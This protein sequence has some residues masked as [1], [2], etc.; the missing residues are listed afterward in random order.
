[1]RIV[2]NS[3]RQNFEPDL[4]TMLVAQLESQLNLHTYFLSR[5]ES[6]GIRL[7][8]EAKLML[9]LPLHEF[10]I[11]DKYQRMPNIQEQIIGSLDSLLETAESKPSRFDSSATDP[12]V[13]QFSNARSSLTI[14]KAYY[15]K[16]CSIPPFCGDDDR[17]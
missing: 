5:E 7:T 11:R 8:A 12:Y 9:M 15:R 16:Y 13:M 10:A 4:I 3:P 2:D 17:E 14:I 1:M 6:L